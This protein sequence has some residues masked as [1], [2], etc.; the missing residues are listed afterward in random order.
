MKLRPLLFLLAFSVAVSGTAN[1]QQNV[2]YGKAKAVASGNNAFAIGFYKKI[3][4]EKGNQFFSPF[5]ISNAFGMVYVGAKGETS[6]EIAKVFHFT[7]PIEKLNAG[8]GELLPLLGVENPDGS[9]GPS[10]KEYELAVANRLWVD[11]GFKLLPTYLETARKFYF[12]VPEMLDLQSAEAVPRINR[13][14]EEK[15]KG[16]IRDLLKETGEECR[17]VLTNAIYFK[18]KWVK[19]FEENR[20]QPEPFTT[21][22]DKKV[23][24]LLMQQT[25]GFRYGETTE[26]QLL[27][28]SYKG[29]ELSMV[30]VLP[31]EI[32]GLSKVE[33]KL[34][35]PE[36]DRWTS[37]LQLSM[38]KKSRR[39]GVM[40]FLPK[41]RMEK[42]LDLTPKL[43][44]MGMPLAFTGRAD[45]SGL[46]AKSQVT[47]PLRID[48][49][50]HKAFVDVDE[51]GTKAAAA[52]GG[53][54][55]MEG[56]AAEP[57]VF[58]ADHPFLFFIRHIPT[59]SILFIGRYV[60][61]KGG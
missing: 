56:L 14:V 38:L 9:S 16:K 20:T 61:P 32:Q 43:V 27:E 26:A 50:L 51:E 45:F 30:I 52:T 59:G 1:A 13:W 41:F 25:G 18:G 33:A 11:D 17:T 49:A 22:S 23:T 21:E 53:P 42:Q 37:I 6:A 39:T 35:A 46:A 7:M 31:K 24:V 44:S 2:A 48:Q 34:S 4:A 36:V 8:F 47:K 57:V 12:S 3:A 40:V 10:K 19:A 28:M 58:R 55:M 29:D 5:S 15:T 60:D 54:R